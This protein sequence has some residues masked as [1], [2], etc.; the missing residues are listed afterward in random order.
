MSL[1]SFDEQVWH[2]EGN[3]GK[4]AVCMMFKP[5]EVV[6]CADRASA[7]YGCKVVIREGTKFNELLKVVYTVELESQRN[8]SFVVDQNKL[9][10]GKIKG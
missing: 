5:G 9:Q 10:I 3:G 4:G 8:V 6:Y 1:R 2:D 7:Y